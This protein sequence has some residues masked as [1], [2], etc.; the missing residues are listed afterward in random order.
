MI[1]RAVAH[2][3]ELEMDEGV[4]PEVPVRS[5]MTLKMRL[6]CACG[7]D[8]SGAA[9]RLITEEDVFALS[10]SSAF[11][12]KAPGRLGTC[13]WV[14]VFPSQEIRGVVHEQVSLPITFVTRPL[15]SSLAIW[16][17]PSPVVI[18]G[19]FRVKVGA[20]SS[21]ACALKGAPVELLDGAG[22]VVG[23][24]H[25][26]DAPWEGTTALYWTDV[27]LTAPLNEGIVSWSVR[28][29]PTDTEV[30]H[31]EAA[32]SFSFAAVRPPDHQLTITLIE[33]DTEKPIENAHI[34]LGAFRTLTDACGVAHLAMPKGTYEVK[35]WHAA[36]ETAPTTVDVMDD[37]HL[38]LVGV[39]VP[40]EDP[41]ARWMM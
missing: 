21:G 24:G 20:K 29:A 17:V 6:S 36:Y 11:A 19:R 37:V 4:A 40:E 14:V 30:P 35:V 8:L 13:S 27:E 23:S 5:D 9:L 7:C 31:D 32:A 38:Q 34:R 39:A 28:F 1:D 12:V 10:E 41:S 33:K 25:L 3:V 2:R 15:A 18:G 22:T 16:D 26:G